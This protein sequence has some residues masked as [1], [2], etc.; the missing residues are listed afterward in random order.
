MLK[1]PL[2]CSFGEKEGTQKLVHL[3]RRPRL[4]CWGAG[5]SRSPPAWEQA[6]LCKPEQAHSSMGR[7]RFPSLLPHALRGLS[8]CPARGQRDNARRGEQRLAFI[9]VH[10]HKQVCFSGSNWQPFCWVC[11]SGNNSWKFSVLSCSRDEF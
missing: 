2:C 6:L 11:K 1:K 8:C 3:E 5:S 7:G 10:T 9:F 4:R